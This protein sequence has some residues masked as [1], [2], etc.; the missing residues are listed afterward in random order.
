MAQK[1]KK[2]RKNIWNVKDWAILVPIGMYCLVNSIFVCVCCFLFVLDLDQTI[3]YF[4][5]LLNT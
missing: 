4:N 5:G 3:W 1:K 2:T